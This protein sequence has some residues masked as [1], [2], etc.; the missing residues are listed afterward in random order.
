MIKYSGN[1]V[2]LKLFQLIKTKFESLHKVATSGSYNDLSNIPETF[3]PETHE[4]TEYVKL[5]GKNQI[6]GGDSASG[7]Y[8]IYASAG[9][10]I[11]IIQ[12]QVGI[13]F[14]SNGSSFK[15]AYA[16]LTTLKPYKTYNGYEFVVDR[17]ASWK[18]QFEQSIDNGITVYKVN[19][20]G[21]KLNLPISGIADPTADNDAVNKAYVD[22]QIGDISTII[23]S[24]NGVVI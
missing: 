24:I 15:I 7:A 18:A 17:N 12:G 6:T 14:N 2:L 5:S 16:D 1:N 4:H 20:N 8:V 3:P 13:F 11:N 19:N 21:E 22:T 9:Y 23:D 10:P